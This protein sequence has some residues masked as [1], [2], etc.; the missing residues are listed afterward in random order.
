[1]RRVLERGS[2][3]GEHDIG[4][5]WNFSMPPRGPIDRGDD[6]DL[7]AQKVHQ[8][9]AAFPMDA[10]VRIGRQSLRQRAGARCG[11]DAGE[12]VARAGQ[13]HHAVVAVTRYVGEGVG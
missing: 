12:L 3:R 9:C 6:R 2:L 5:Q 7:D 13:D 8:Q 10:V 11:A 4:Q 1:M